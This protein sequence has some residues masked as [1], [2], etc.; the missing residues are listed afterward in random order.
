MPAEHPPP[1]DTS[2]PYAEISDVSYAEEAARR[3]V[4]DELE[5]GTL[6]LRGPCPRCRAAI[7]LPAVEAIFRSPRVAGSWLRRSAPADRNTHVEPMMCTCDAD[8][9]GRP[10]GLAGCGAYWTLTIV[11][12]PR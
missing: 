8:H 3:F 5:P 2:L 11:A 10:E 6:I 1:H 12:V 7:D 4:V 9:A